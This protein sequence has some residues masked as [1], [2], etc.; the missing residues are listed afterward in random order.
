MK[1]IIAI[2]L[3]ALACAAQDNAKGQL[4]SINP[5]PPAQ[6]IS[7]LNFYDASNNQIYRCQAVSV[8]PT[9]T[10]TVTAKTLTSIVDSSNTA[11]ATTSTDHG[12]SVGNA[13]TIA[14]ATDTDLNGTYIIATVPGT[15]T[16]T[17]TTASVTDATYNGAALT[18]STTAP[19]SSVAIWS[20]RRYQYSGTNLTHEQW[21]GG[22]TSMNKICDNRASLSAQ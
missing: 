1:T 18:M 20:I 22:S 9:Y 19:R 3:C 15:T 16:F 8:Q 17:I 12:L 14:G 7:A 13:V 2:L 4:V 10:W 6:P 21:V 5:G 11:T